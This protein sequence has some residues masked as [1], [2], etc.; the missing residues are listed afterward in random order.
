[1]TTYFSKEDRLTH[2][3]KSIDSHTLKRAGTVL[4]RNSIWDGPNHSSSTHLSRAKPSRTRGRRTGFYWLKPLS[5]IFSKPPPP[6]SPSYQCS[7]L[8][9]SL[10]RM[11]QTPQSYC[12]S[13]LHKQWEES[14]KRRTQVCSCTP[15]AAADGCTALKSAG[16]AEMALQTY[17]EAFRLLKQYFLS[18][19]LCST[20]DFLI[21]SPPPCYL[22]CGSPF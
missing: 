7:I 17:S 15:P 20:H 16:Q 2:V 12:P 11:A 18:I 19:Y 3:V 9:L 6:F 1:M 22:P 13:R 5:D 14:R 4:C 10:H 8:L 21:I